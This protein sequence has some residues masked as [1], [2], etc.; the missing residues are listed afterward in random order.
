MVLNWFRYNIYSFPPTTDYLVR[1]FVS[2]LLRNAHC[3]ENLPKQLLCAGSHAS[4]DLRSWSFLGSGSSGVVSGFGGSTLF[5]MG[6]SGV[7][8]STCLLPSLIPSHGLNGGH[9]RPV[10]IPLDCFAQHLFSLEFS[11]TWRIAKLNSRIGD[12]PFLR[13]S[14]YLFPGCATTLPMLVCC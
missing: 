13:P 1:M 6:S 14:R 2:S 3:S 7:W 12:C 11:L 8:C 5:V 4:F 10:N 9:D